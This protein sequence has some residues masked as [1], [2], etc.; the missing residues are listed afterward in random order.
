MKKFKRT[1]DHNKIK[2]NYSYDANEVCEKLGT[3]KG[4]VYSWVREGLKPIDNISPYLFHG[5][6]LRRFLKERQKKRKHKCKPNEMFCLKC[7]RPR[8]PQQG[9]TSIITTKGNNP[10]I[11]GFCTI[12]NTQMNKAVS[13][14]NL[15]TCLKIFNLQT[16]DNL[17]LAGCDAP[18]TINNKNKGK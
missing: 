13:Q 18:L 9:K 8:R 1:F 5:T 10:I 17:H 2:I 4:T 3:T 12:C 15:K 16:G 14:E 6:E 7:Q 11:R